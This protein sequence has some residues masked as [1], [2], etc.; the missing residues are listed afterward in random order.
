MSLHDLPDASSARVRGRFVYTALDPATPRA[1][2]VVSLEPNLQDGLVSCRIQHT[3]LDSARYSALSYQCGTKDDSQQI[4]VDGLNF[5][6]RRNLWDF[7]NQARET[8]ISRTFWVDALSIS[9][10]DDQEKSRQVQMM[11]Q[12]YQNAGEVLIWLGP[13][14]HFS[15]YAWKRVKEFYRMGQATSVREVAEA[16]LKDDDLWQGLEEVYTSA[17][18][19]RAW[20]TQ[21]YLLWQNCRILQGLQ[22]LLHAAER[23]SGCE[24][25][26]YRVLPLVWL[27]RVSSLSWRA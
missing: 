5:T 19:E 17:Y 12:I 22:G 2:R 16:C 27:S 23:S 15:S 10:E 4:L 11:G 20:I 9:Q 3:D 18:W 21:E 13:H 1:I 7:L 14:T 24:Y 26:Q 8:L 25:T 6:V